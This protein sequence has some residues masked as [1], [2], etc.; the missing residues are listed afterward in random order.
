MQYIIHIGF[1]N[2][3]PL[4][5]VLFTVCIIICTFLSYIDYCA[6]DKKGKKPNFLGKIG[7]IGITSFVCTN[8]LDL[9]IRK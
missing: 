5:Y 3:I 6:G 7:G 1:S 9:N 8:F 4:V 2:T